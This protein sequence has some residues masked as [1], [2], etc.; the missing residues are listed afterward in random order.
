MGDLS[1][2]AII[3]GLTNFIANVSSDIAK[4]TLANMSE[5]LIF[6][7]SEVGAGDRCG[8]RSGCMFWR[9]GLGIVG[10]HL[11]LTCR[12]VMPL[13]KL[14]CQECKSALCGRKCFKSERLHV[15][16]AGLALSWWR[17]GLVPFNR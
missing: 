6:K 2:H 11:G 16:V 13:P 1:L 5:G 9:E 14:G 17:E 10:K 15:P 4:W 7:R 3:L 12:K 8:V